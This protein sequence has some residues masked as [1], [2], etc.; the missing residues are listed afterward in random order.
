MQ[1]KST[2]LEGKPTITW[3]KNGAWG[4]KETP[5]PRLEGLEKDPPK[6]P[7]KA[8]V[9]PSNPQTPGQNFS[10]KDYDTTDKI[11]P[12]SQPL[13]P[14]EEEES[15]TTVA[16]NETNENG[17]LS[18]PRAEPNFEETTTQTAKDCQI[19]Q[20][21]LATGP[22]K[23]AQDISRT[24]TNLMFDGKV[25]AAIKYLDENA[26]NAVLKPTPEVV[27]KLQ[28]LHPAPS[29]I[30]P[31][32]LYHGPLNQ[33]STAYF[34]NITE[35]TVR[36]AA[37]Q[38]KGS[39]G[40]SLFDSKQW[41]RILCSNSF[42]VE[43]K[44]LRIRIA[45]FAK[46]ISTEI[47]D[48]NT[49]EAY[50][51]GR[52]LA[53]DKAPGDP[54]LQVR[55]IAVGEVLRRIVGK[56]IAWSLN[57]EIQEAAGPLQVST[58]LK[59]GAEAAIHSMKKIFELEGTDA[60]I[61]VDA[62][63]A[64][65]RLNR[66][67]ALHNIQYICP[68]FSTILINT[69][70][71]SAR[72]IILGGGEILSNEGT[73]QGDT[74][75]MAFYGLCTNPILQSSKQRIP[76]VHQVWLADDAT[77]AGNLADLRNWWDLIKSDGVKYGYYVKPSKSWLVL[78]NPDKLEDCKRLFESSPINITVQGKRHLGASIGS[79]EFKNSYIDD[80]VAKWKRNIERL[81]EIAQSQP[82]A[83]YA[84]FIHAEQHKYTYFLRTIP[85]ISANLKPLDDAISDLFI[86]ALFGNEIDEN[87]R[88]I[89]SLPI[90]DGGLGIKKV[91]M[92]SD[93][94]Y[95]TSSQ[96]TL[97]LTKQI[98]QQS[99]SLPDADEVQTAKSKATQ[100]LKESEKQRATAIV[101]A[102]DEATKRT[103]DQLSEPG[104]SSW[105]GTLP[106]RSQ[107]L[108]LNKGEFQD[109]LA[110]RYNR[111][112][113]NLPSRCPCGQTFDT[114]HALNCHLGGFINARHDIIRDF[115]YDLLK[116]VVHD[117][118]KEPGLQPV[119]NKVGH[120]RTAKLEDD[121][122]LDIRARGFWRHGQNSFFDVRV[123][124]TDSDSQQNSSLKSILQKHE[125]EKKRCYNRRI[126]EVEHGSFTPLVFTTTGVMS[127]ECS[128]FHKALAEK[129]SVKQGERYEEVMR[130]L[131]VKL[132]FLALKSTLLC[133]RGSRSTSRTVNVMN[134]DFGLALNDLGL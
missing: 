68:P 92:S 76:S 133:L 95:E 24:F 98:F 57:S 94:A 2:R 81:A 9:K 118:E 30:L 130:F 16:G 129:I 33:I 100:F 73:T 116:A 41:R 55:P 121:A 82:H 40:P 56:T 5:T 71:T 93:V 74:L 91:R 20:K 51:A 43:A 102:Q 7:K 120:L 64:F 79:H 49:L 31:E 122:R 26:E 97:P 70:R 65:N 60:V 4:T 109:A 58:G 113:K 108:N 96:L 29:D 132:S 72:L 53:L 83:A 59:G 89:L 105:L 32:T 22:K 27:E 75:A 119:V 99:S 34:D 50:L 85:G 117:V 63:N 54:E 101:E 111:D 104:A 115:E 78:K 61:L 38:T 112:I 1:R 8:V 107:G 11:L 39:G 127:H 124:N 35:E 42:K 47:V 87:T 66:A 84:A 48:P 23:S 10:H 69:Y 46:K 80:K 19:V 106:L 67:V 88:D 44:E 14:L 125:T 62:A 17:L 126:M 15:S 134:S 110:I 21:K 128:I 131:R 25:G 13:A 12:P 86:P 114:T 90:R 28:S 18:A 123:T 36:K 45:A 37:S 77:G 3:K 52:L 103:I 6:P